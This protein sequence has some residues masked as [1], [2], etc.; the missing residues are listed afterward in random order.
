M[1]KNAVQN[2]L[3]WAEGLLFSAPKEAINLVIDATFFGRKYGY[4]CVHDGSKIIF[5]LCLFRDPVLMLRIP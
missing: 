2:V 4:F 5:L 3:D 1:P